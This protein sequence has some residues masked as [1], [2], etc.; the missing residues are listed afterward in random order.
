MPVG[1]RSATLLHNGFDLRGLIID[2]F[3]LNSPSEL[4]LSIGTFIDDSISICCGDKICSSLQSRCIIHSID[5]IRSR[6]MGVE[7]STSLDSGSDVG[8][9]LL[10]DAIRGKTA[11]NPGDPVSGIGISFLYSTLDILHLIWDAIL[12]HNSRVVNLQSTLSGYRMFI[13]SMRSLMISINWDIMHA[14]ILYLPFN[15]NPA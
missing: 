9:S 2:E 1:L 4:G 15:L 12:I 13:F 11:S 5:F 8:M 14:H 6:V 10:F 7:N 3:Q